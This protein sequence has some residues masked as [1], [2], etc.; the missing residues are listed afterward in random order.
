MRK[1]IEEGTNEDPVEPG[2][3]PDDIDDVLI[4]GVIAANHNKHTDAL[5]GKVLRRQ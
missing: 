1:K 2:K 3:A 4:N 5:A